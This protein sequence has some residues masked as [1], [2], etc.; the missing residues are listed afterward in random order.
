MDRL[1]LIST[2]SLYLGVLSVGIALG[3]SVGLAA[4]QPACTSGAPVPQSAILESG[5]G[6]ATSVCWSNAK[7]LQ[8]VANGA[9][10]SSAALLLGGGVLDQYGTELRERVRS[11][12]ASHD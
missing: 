4:I 11:W 5:S 12:R 8:S 1:E 2:V 7:L 3:A 10:Y 9:A 6:T